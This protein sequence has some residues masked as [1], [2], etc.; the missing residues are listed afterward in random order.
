ML[1]PSEQKL[2]CD[3]EEIGSRGAY[4]DGELIE[5]A[6]AITT[7][8]ERAV[9]AEI[10]LVTNGEIE[11]TNQVEKILAW[12]KARDCELPDLQKGTLAHALRRSSLTPEVR[13]VI[14]LRREAAHASAGKVQSLR[15]WR[16]P[17]GRVRGCFKFHGAATGRWSGVGPQLQNFR[18]ESENTAAKLAAVM[19]GDIEVV[20]NLGAPIEVVGDIARALICAEPGRRL[21]VGDFSGIESRVLAWIAGEPT[22]LAQWAKF[23]QTGDPADD[24]YVVIGRALGHPEE[25]ARKFGKIADLAFGYQGGKGAYANFAPEDDTAT[26]EQIE[27]FKLA[28]RVRHPEIE[29]FW[30][31]IERAAVSALHRSP[32]VVHYG[33]LT[34]RCEH[35]HGLRFLF[36]TLPSGRALAYPGVKLIRNKYDQ[37]AVMFMDNA[38]G[39]WTEANHGRGAYGGLFTENIVSGIARDLLAAAMQRLE[40]AGYPVVLHVHDEI[41]CELPNSEGS[42]EEF[43]YLIERLPEWAEGLPVAA[44][45]RSGPRWAEVDVPV[46]HV[47]GTL[48]APP[49]KAKAKRPAKRA[50]TA[51][52]VLPEAMSFNPAMLDQMAL[53]AVERE[54]AR[55]RKEV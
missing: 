53:W 35:R 50:S 13:R 8:A 5:K 4:C 45:V 1:I 40:A 36:I 37:P 20:K 41:V 32:Q 22:K 6:L 34:L 43:R 48:E 23:D 54:A 17:D 52:A 21:L 12:L 11:T 19:T 10:K 42:L 51:P 27:E 29:R 31:G 30:K 18:R 9:Q 2:W 24:P 46:V 38:L 28:W 3:S 47:A 26:E 14:E 15:A 55:R 7:A 25:T 39:Q 16:C 49:P 33:R 44:K